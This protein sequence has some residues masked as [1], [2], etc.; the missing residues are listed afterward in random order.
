MARNTSVTLGNHFEAFIRQQVEAGRYGTASEVLRAALRLL[1]EREA[2][3][4]ALRAALTEGEESGPAEPLDMD[5]I[6]DEARREAEI[7]G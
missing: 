7:R 5:A 1:E 6:L 4:A 3:L 2:R